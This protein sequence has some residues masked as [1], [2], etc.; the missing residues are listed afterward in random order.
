MKQIING[1][2]YDVQTPSDSRDLWLRDK[3]VHQGKVKTITGV[4][5][6]DTFELD[7]NRSI[8]YTYKELIKIIE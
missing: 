8:S 2:E 1:V 7:Y 3:V 6:Y 4:T 5:G